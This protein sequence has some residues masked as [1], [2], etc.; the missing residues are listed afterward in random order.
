MRCMPQHMRCMPQRMRCM[1][2][3]MRCMQR[4]CDAAAYATYTA[5]HATYIVHDTM[6]EVYYGEVLV[7]VTLKGLNKEILTRLML[8][9]IAV[10]DAGLMFTTGAAFGETFALNG[11]SYLSLRFVG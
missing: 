10:G 3:R 1:Q 7:G 2:R 9:T 6:L 5:T 4:C 8:K 11:G